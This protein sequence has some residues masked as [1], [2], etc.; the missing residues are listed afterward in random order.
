LPFSLLFLIGYRGT[1]K[2]TVAR[3][4]AER[5]G[6]KW[7]DAD[8]FLESRYGSTIGHI[9]ENE[10][11]A[12][13]REHEAAAL[14]DF[15]NLRQHVIGTGGGVVLRDENRKRLQG[16]GKVVWLTADPLTIWRR[17]QLDPTTTARRPALTGG[18]LAEVEE[19]VRI[20]EPLYRSCAHLTISTA[21]ISPPEVAAAIID[22]LGQ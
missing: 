21:D 2:T 9:F 17:L 8:E 20:R 5:L 12:V 16:A 13:F 19:L 4:L 14:K 1:G 18:G 3:H 6:W 11:E 7:I 10:G 15:C 22:Q